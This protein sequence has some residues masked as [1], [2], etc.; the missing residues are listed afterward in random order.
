MHYDI[1]NRR[2]HLITNSDN[3]F[4]G[5]II[6]WVSLNHIAAKGSDLWYENW[7]KSLCLINYSFSTCVLGFENHFNPVIRKKH[8]YWFLNTL[9]Y[10][11]NSL[12]FNRTELN[13]SYYPLSLHQIWLLNII[14]NF[15]IVCQK[16]HTFG[17]QP[18]LWILHSTLN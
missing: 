7:I 9:N 17:V 5:Y 1:R 12:M 11:N 14:R 18:S 15:K 8:F 4:M 10:L 6:K 2:T 3:I 16:S 13:L